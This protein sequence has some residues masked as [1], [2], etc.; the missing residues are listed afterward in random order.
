VATCDYGLNG[1]YFEDILED[2]DSEDEECLQR[3]IE[4]IMLTSMQSGPSISYT[5]RQ[6]IGLEKLLEHRFCCSV[7]RT[8]FQA[9][10]IVR[11][12]CKHIYCTEC[13]KRLFL[14]SVKDEALFPPRCCRQEI[15]LERVAAALLPEEM[16]SFQAAKIEYSVKDRTYCSN[17]DCARFIPPSQIVADRA[18]CA[19]CDEETCA[20]CKGEFHDGECP[21][22]RAM[23]AT[24]ALA[25]EEGWRR[26]HSCRAMVELTYGCN[27]MQ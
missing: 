22:D 15:P 20:Y 12:G 11:L 21:E 24:L 16:E 14:L 8:K 3:T 9:Y 19:N 18:T 27:H 5:E 7:C 1:Q 13:L 23:Q 26:C 4:L 6:R 25:E 17:S 2:S 10:K